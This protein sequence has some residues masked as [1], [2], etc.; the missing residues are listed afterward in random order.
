M[1]C[2]KW[3]NTFEYGFYISSQMWL[4]ISECRFRVDRNR[5]NER[6][7]FT[8]LTWASFLAWLCLLV[9]LGWL[10]GQSA[11]HGLAW[12]LLLDCGMIR[13]SALSTAGS[14]SVKSSWLSDV[15][16]CDERSRRLFC[17]SGVRC[18]HDKLMLMRRTSARHPGA[19]HAAPLFPAF[20]KTLSDRVFY[21]APERR[22]KAQ[23]DTSRR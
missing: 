6:N 7:T 4:L 8:K 23:S 2:C 1:T 11:R 13:P 22:T 12:H 3:T 5:T 20:D 10:K 21:R 19:P 16:P 17:L 9:T 14:E 18:C 15:L